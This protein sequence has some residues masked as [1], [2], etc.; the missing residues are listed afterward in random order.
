ML[1]KLHLQTDYESYNETVLTQMKGRSV[2]PEHPP[3]SPKISDPQ[4]SVSL[5]MLSVFSSSKEQL[6]EA[7]E[8]DVAR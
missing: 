7:S 3:P 4:L 8:D 6:A 1:L 5:L 2:M